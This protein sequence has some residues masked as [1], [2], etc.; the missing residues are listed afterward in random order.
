[1]WLLTTLNHGFAE[2]G[3]TYAM[4]LGKKIDECIAYDRKIVDELHTIED[5]KWYGM[6]LSEHIGFNDWCEEGCK[7]PVV[8]T[9]EPA[10][11]ERLIV[12]VKGSDFYTEGKFWTGHVGAVD[13]FLN[14][15]NDE[16]ELILSTAGRVD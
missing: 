15:S 1:M 3:S 11:K 16:A 5:G 7:Y 14:P 12:S 4:T 13:A 10:N 2:Q 6:G 8:H 9:F